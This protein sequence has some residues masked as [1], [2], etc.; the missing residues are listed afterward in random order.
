MEPV[1]HLMTGACLARAGLNRRATYATLAM[2]VAAEAPD[3]DILWGSGGPVAGFEHHRGITHTFVGL[4]FVAAGVVG[5]V[6]LL[7]RWRQRG[8]RE[9]TTK[10][11]V[12]WGLL[13][14]FCV[15]A[16]L[17]HLLLDWTNNYGL[18]PFFP[19]NPRWYA[20]SFVFIFEPVLF[21]VLLLAL[22][23]PQF[24]GLIGS[25][26]GAKRPAFRGQ[27]WAIF[28]LLVMVGL[29]GWR[30]VEHQDALT[31]IGREYFDGA[32]K[33]RIFASPYPTDPY[34]WHAVVETPDHFQTATVDTGSGEVTTAGTADVIYKPQATLATLVAKRS[35]LGRVYLDWSMY[36]V[37]EQTGV[38]AD[39]V[40]TVSFRDLRFGYDTFLVHASDAGGVGAVRADRPLPL[41]GTVLVDAER[42]VVAMK[43]DGRVQ[44]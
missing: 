10:A 44:R 16:L 35:W 2:T 19:F 4:P 37:V 41:S 36:P 14:G 27:G 39:G 31:L 34:K 25:E 22:V 23:A 42:R 29:W 5:A 8:G 9:V 32:P 30:W 3:L 13:Y 7:H 38:D 17:S 28:A 20:G 18:R 12:R 1:T 11:P 40:A 43:M 15:I 24:F 21:A 26:V 6:W 33:L